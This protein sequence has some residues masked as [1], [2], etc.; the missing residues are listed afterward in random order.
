MAFWNAPLDDPEHAKHACGCALAM[1]DAL[2]D[3]NRTM[4]ADARAEGRAFYPLQI[5]IGLNTGECVV[6]NVGSDQR[7]DYSAIGDAVNLASRLESQ[8]KTYGIPIIMSESTLAEVP[9][10]AAVEVDLIVVRGKEEAIRIYTLLGD[11]SAGRSE[12]FA[13]LSL[14]HERLLAAYRESRWDDAQAA[15]EMCRSIEPRLAHL[16]DL[17][18]ARISRFRDVPPPPGWRGIYVAETK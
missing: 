18:R 15:L 17:Y 9:G 14:S 10:W 6:G 8:S 13:Q 2:H 4:E 3:I 11:D 16:Y 7:F 1:I 12:S 5:G